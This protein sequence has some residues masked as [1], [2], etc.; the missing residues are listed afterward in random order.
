V[1]RFYKKAAAFVLRSVAKHSPELAQAVVDSGA[2]EALVMCLEEFDPSVKE[3]AGWALGY[4][5]SHTAELAQAVVD[6][7]AV[8]LLVLCIQEPE[9]SLKRITASALNDISKHSPEVCG[10]RWCGVGCGAARVVSSACHGGI[11]MRRNWWT[12]YNRLLCVFYVPCSVFVFR[13]LCSVFCVCSSRR[14]SWMLAR[15][16]TSCL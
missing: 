11:A 2:L 6:A 13:I 12:L 4:I 1:Q 5:A 14:P 16:R 8:P 3:S 9:I 10:V 15:W 7:G